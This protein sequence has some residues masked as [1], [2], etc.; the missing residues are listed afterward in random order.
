MPTNPPR[1]AE[2]NR[3]DCPRAARTTLLAVVALAALVTQVPAAAPTPTA[4]RSFG[5]SVEV[6]VVNLDVLVTAADG[7]PVLDLG[8]KDF[9]IMVDGEPVP[10]SHFA[11]PTS[12]SGGTRPVAEEVSEE[13]PAV[14][15]AAEGRQYVIVFVDL[16][17][18]DRQ[19]LRAGLEQVSEFLGGTGKLPVPVM[20]MSFDGRVRICQ[21]FTQNREA[22]MASLDCCRLSSATRLDLGHEKM[23]MRRRISQAS[24]AEVPPSDPGRANWERQVLDLYYQ[25]EQSFDEVARDQT[26]AVLDGLRHC[27]GMLAGIPGRKSIVLMSDGVDAHATR[28][29]FEVWRGTFARVQVRR[30]RDLVRALQRVL[31][32]SQGYPHAAP[33]LRQLVEVANAHRITFFTLTSLSDRLLRQISAEGGSASSTE[34]AFAEL[35]EEIVLYRMADLTGG[36]I[37]SAGPDLAKQLRKVSDELGQLYLLAFVPPVANDGKF[38]RIQVSVDRDGVTVNHRRGW[39]ASTDDDQLVAKTLAAAGMETTDNPLDISVEEIGRE[40]DRSGELKVDIMVRVPIA[41]L[42]LLP[43][44]KTHDGATSLCLV[45]RDESERLSKVYR[46]AFPVTVPD[47]QLERALASAAGFRKVLQMR[48]GGGL[49]AVGIR[50]DVANVVA[51]AVLRVDPTSP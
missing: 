33:E 51:T 15:P 13:A 4:P 11:P 50:D 18:Y 25:I 38:H 41:R 32:K 43:G 36:R 22:L 49:I 46:E 3:G 7:S 47:D 34:G 12:L 37:L 23:L 2:R 14:A 17:N 42:V 6:P 48:K 45:I 1:L 21:S 24:A 39:R 28:T 44:T 8:A 26:E 40:T 20:V 30:E 29:M 19:R 9:Q 5:G 31:P 27:V 35:G 10:L 16:T